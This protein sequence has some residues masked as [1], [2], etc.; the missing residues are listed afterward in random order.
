MELPAG[1]GFHSFPAHPSTQCPEE[2]GCGRC[3]LA[4]SPLLQ[5]WAWEMGSLCVLGL[6]GV[7]IY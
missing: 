4:L 5:H 7:C 2:L 6:P 1:A 3:V